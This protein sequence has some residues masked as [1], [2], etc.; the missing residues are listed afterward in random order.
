MIRDISL[1]TIASTSVI[2]NFT[3]FLPQTGL[4]QSTFTEEDEQTEEEDAAD[5]L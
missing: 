5:H 4:D 3:F 2:T 1:Y